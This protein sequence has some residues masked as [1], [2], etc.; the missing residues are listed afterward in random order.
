M[1]M[2]D[3][4]RLRLLAQSCADEVATKSLLLRA[5]DNL[6]RVYSDPNNATILAALRHFQADRENVPEDIMEIALNGWSCE[7][8]SNEAIDALCESLNV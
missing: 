5:A 7:P 1:K 4:D 8:L 2:K 6:D 3:V